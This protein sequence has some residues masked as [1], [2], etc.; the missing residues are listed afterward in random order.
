MGYS[1]SKTQLMIGLGVSSI[2]DSWSSF[3]ECKF[4]RLL[5]NTRMEQITGFR[6]H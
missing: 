6:G 2:S 5:S 3:A 1:S 4:R